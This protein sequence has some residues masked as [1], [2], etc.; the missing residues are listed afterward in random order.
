MAYRT[1]V[2][3]EICLKHHIILNGCIMTLLDEK[4]THSERVNVHGMCR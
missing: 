4:I 3:L 1:W 2:L